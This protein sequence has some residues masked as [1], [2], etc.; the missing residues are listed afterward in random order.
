MG[1]LESVGAEAEVRFAS[2]VTR[3][4][5]DHLHPDAVVVAG[6]RGYRVARHHPILESISRFVN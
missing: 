5:H 4:Y 2:D 1:A 6:T 3:S